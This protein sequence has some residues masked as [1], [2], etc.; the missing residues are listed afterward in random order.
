MPNAA[1][2]KLVGHV[3]ER[4][5][6]TVWLLRKLLGEPVSRESFIAEGTIK[7][8]FLLRRP[9]V[10]NHR[11]TSRACWV[12]RWNC[13][14]KAK[15]M[16]I[17]DARSIPLD[18]ARKTA[19]THWAAIIQGRD[20]AQE[21]REQ[22]N[23]M[24]VAAIWAEYT[25]D[26][27]F[28]A[29]SAGTQYKDRNRYNLHAADRIGSKFV[30]ELGM[31][32]VED[33]ISAI[34]SDTRIGRRGRKLGGEGAAKKVLRL[35][36]TITAWALKRGLVKVNPFIGHALCP[37]GTRTEIVEVVRIQPGSPTASIT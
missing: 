30:D 11:H 24:T 4:G 17:G 34:C 19:Q 35:L 32:T 9:P 3:D 26:Q 18:A 1:I 23:R 31:K 22:R 7:G 8:L 20:P 2:S 28:T 10:K 5:M 21:R 33:F 25:A 15:K 36:S 12:L 13:S 29:K 6:L 16:V 37:D 14:G 27:K